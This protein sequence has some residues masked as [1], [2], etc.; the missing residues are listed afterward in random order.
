MSET[1]YHQLPADYA[2]IVGRL[3][4]EAGLDPST[5]SSMQEFEQLRELTRLDAIMDNKLDNIDTLLDF[6]GF[7]AAYMAEQRK[8]VKLKIVNMHNDS[9]FYDGIM[10]RLKQM[11]LQFDDANPTLTIYLA[12]KLNAIRD[13]AH[14]SHVIQLGTFHLAISPLLNPL[15]PAQAYYDRISACRGNFVNEGFQVTLPATYRALAINL[16]AHEILNMVAKAGSH[17]SCDATVTWDLPSMTRRV[18][19]I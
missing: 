5:I 17:D 14:P 18:Y 15:Y 11:K 12:D 10:V 6:A 13:A 2:S 7:P 8:H 16:V 1:S 3:Q 19:G 4:S 9:T